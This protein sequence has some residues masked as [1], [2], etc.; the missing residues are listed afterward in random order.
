[1]SKKDT[2]AKR[3]RIICTRM[4]DAG[5]CTNRRSYHLDDIER[6]VVGGL[7][8]QLGS[9]EAIGYFVHCYNDE[10]RPASADSG[11]KRRKLESEIANVDRQIERAVTAIIEG[12]IT[13]A[14]AAAH[15]PGLRQ[16][17]GQLTAELAAL[18]MRSVVLKLRS[19]IVD[20]YLRDLGR[21]EELINSDMAAGD[22]GAARTIRSMIETV[23]VMPVTG[24]ATARN[25][26]AR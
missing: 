8:D 22:D 6:L 9:A 16:R 19:A 14:E 17:R 7:R 25:H 10:R 2:S 3:P 20:S 12:R 1:M 26:R 4:H 21:L 5:M 11:D 23:T 15:L 13:E 24:R 18:G